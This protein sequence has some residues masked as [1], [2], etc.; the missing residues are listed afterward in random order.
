[1]NKWCVFLSFGPSYNLNTNLW[2]FSMRRSNVQDVSMGEA[3]SAQCSMEPKTVPFR[4]NN[5]VNIKTITHIS[6]CVFNIKNKG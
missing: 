2:H 6:K 4:K 5:N 1:M 3:N